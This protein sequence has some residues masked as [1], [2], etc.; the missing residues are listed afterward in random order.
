[1]PSGGFLADFLVGIFSEEGLFFINIYLPVFGFNTLPSGGFLVDFLGA[2]FSVIG[3]FF[4]NI[5]RPV[6]GFNT[7]PSGG[8]LEDFVG[9]LSLRLFFKLS[10]PV[11]TKYGVLSNEYVSSTLTYI[12]VRIPSLKL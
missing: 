6:L 9:F 12:N 2:F 5:Y 1:M 7:L 8:F 11:A 3:L 10:P 4:I